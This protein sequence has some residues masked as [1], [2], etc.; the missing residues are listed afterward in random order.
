MT[1]Q[2]HRQRAATVEELRA[3]A[4]TAIRARLQAGRQVSAAWLAEAAG[5]TAGGALAFLREHATAGRL[6]RHLAPGGPASYLDAWTV[7]VPTDT[8]PT[9]PATT[10]TKE[11][12]S[13][14]PATTTSP[15]TGFPGEATTSTT[16]APA[17]GSAPSAPAACASSSTAARPGAF[18]VLVTGS[19]TWTDAAAITGVLTDL[20]EVHGDRL[21]VVHGA[22]RTGADRIADGWARRHG[23]ATETHPADWAAGPGAGPARNAAM[24]ATSPDVCLAFI[25]DGS[26]GAT[27]CA[28][29]AERAGIPT[30]R[31]TAVQREP[32]ADTA[33]PDL[34]PPAL[35]M[36]AAQPTAQ[37]AGAQ[38]HR[39]PSAE[40]S[41]QLP[42]VTDVLFA[43]LDLVGR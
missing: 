42:D 31:H 17:A 29:A 1:R 26:P 25:R 35:P 16:C 27:G 8:W 37:P 4:T 38:R 30:T 32:A 41:V 11:E 6:T 20:H 10:T 39:G 5:L 23:V 34:A 14:A 18:R 22:C 13:W 3:R 24:V 40:T 7:A 12:P 43:D 9:T 19:R 21:V 15:G 36:Q 33:P 2:Q 28:D